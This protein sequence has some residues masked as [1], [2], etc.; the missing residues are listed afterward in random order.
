[1]VSQNKV[2]YNHHPTHPSILTYTRSSY[3]LYVKARHLGYKRG[4]HTQQPNTSLVQLESVSSAEEARWYLGKRIAFIYRG[5]K[6]DKK[7][8]KTRKIWGK[9]TRVHGNS[10]VVRAKF[11]VPLPPRSFGAALHVVSFLNHS[12]LF[13]YLN[14]LAI[15]DVSFKHLNISYINRQ[16]RNKLTRLQGRGLE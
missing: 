12:S 6:A 4:K 10:G 15:D 16:R 14:S 11:S 5:S 8:S 9:V 13:S 1:M 3:S 7:G 2:R